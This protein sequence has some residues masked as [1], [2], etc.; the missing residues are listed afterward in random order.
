MKTLIKRIGC[1]SVAMAATLAT[2]M[3]TG[4]TPD[5]AAEAEVIYKVVGG[6]SEPTRVWNETQ[7]EVVAETE[8]EA[9]AEY[10][11]D[12]CALKN[13]MTLI[14]QTNV[15]LLTSDV[16]GEVVETLAEGTEIVAVGTT[17]KGYY[18]TEEGN[19]ICATGLEVKVETEEDTKVA[20]TPTQGTTTATTTTTTTTTT[21]TSAPA[22]TTEA[23]PAQEAPAQEQ[24][25][26]EP[27]QTTEAPAQEQ[28]AE[29]PALEQTESTSWWDVDPMNNNSN[30]DEGES[31]AEWEEMQNA[32]AADYDP[33]KEWAQSLGYDSVE[34]AREAGYDVP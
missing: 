2:V 4:C 15:D 28:T 24:T 33:Y 32:W 20:D 8:V 18:V 26:E 5:E 21:S 31:M 9:E 17:G 22:Q 27:Q 14:A 1:V 16:D 7:A 3:L 11:P 25:Y 19:F 6:I 12:V 34:E 23:A 30:Y 13:P 29:T 10:V